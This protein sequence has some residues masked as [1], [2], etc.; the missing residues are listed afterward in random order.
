MLSK[1][2]KELIEKIIIAHV[3]YQRPIRSI[4][5]LY[6]INGDFVRRVLSIY[7]GEGKMAIESLK[8]GE[9]VNELILSTYLCTNLTLIQ[10]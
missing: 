5:S 6:A 7:Y 1:M 9:K 3:C 8:S 10:K 4:S 2:D